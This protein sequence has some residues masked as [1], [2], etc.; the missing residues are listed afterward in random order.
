MIGLQALLCRGAL[1]DGFP[2][3]P[4]DK[5]VPRSDFANRAQELLL[6]FVDASG[7]PFQRKAAGDC[8]DIASYDY[9]Y[10]PGFG[11]EVLKVT[12]GSNPA[13]VTAALLGTSRSGRSN[14]SSSFL[15][16]GNDLPL[17]PVSGAPYSLD[18]TGVVN[19]VSKSG[20]AVG[21]RTQITGKTSV[22][23]SDVSRRAHQPTS[24]CGP[25]GCH[26]WDVRD[27]PEVPR[28]EAIRV[29]A[30]QAEPSFRSPDIECETN[31]LPL[32]PGVEIG[33]ERGAGA[34]LSDNADV[35]GSFADALF[36]GLCQFDHGPA[37]FGPGVNLDNL[38]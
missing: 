9:G 32:A 12:P 28:L 31:L 36:A 38:S 29:I 34:R 20:R 19:C 5:A 2:T 3:K 10:T 25:V 33:R 23:L 14:H 21:P 1:P 17:A 11:E 4:G 6:F 18:E 7:G 37:N 24:D 13:L 8:Y 22:D 27:E 15:P 30:G 26:E 16:I 35:V